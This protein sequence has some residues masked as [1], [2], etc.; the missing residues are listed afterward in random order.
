M[1]DTRAATAQSPITRTLWKPIAAALRRSG[2]L[3]IDG[4]MTMG[5]AC[6]DPM[7]CNAYWIGSNPA[8]WGAR[9]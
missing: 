9:K 2:Q 7:T 4:L 1:E 3:L 8:I 5:A 6:C